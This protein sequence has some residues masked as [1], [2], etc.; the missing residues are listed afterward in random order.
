MLSRAET[1][2]RAIT[3]Q[4]LAYTAGDLHETILLGSSQNSSL[5][6]SEHLRLQASIKDY[7]GTYVL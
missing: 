1:D 4:L 2:F 3:L 7:L 6:N 5:G